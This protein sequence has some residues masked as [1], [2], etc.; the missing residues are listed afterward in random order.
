MKKILI[1]LV[2]SVGILVGCQSDPVEFDHE[3]PQ[4]EIR[5]NA[6]LLELIAPTGTTADDEI[7]I[8]GAF[9]GLNDTTAV[10]QLEW[11]LEKAQ[12]SD[13]KWGI[14]LQPEDFVNGKT[15]KDGFSFVSVKE[16][17]E[18]DVQ[19]KPM[20]HQLDVT[21]GTRTN[22]WSNRWASYFSNAEETIKHD[23]MVIYVLDES[24]FADLSLYMYGEI[25]DLNGAWPGM[26]PTGKE[27]INGVEYT[28]FDTG[29]DN[30]GL[31]ETLI[32]SDNGTNQLADYG[33]VLLEENIYLHIH[34]DGTIEAISAS[35]TVEH[36]GAVV[37]VLDGMNWGMNTTLYMW[38]DVNDLNGG[39]PGMKVGGTATI[40]E[41]TYIYFD[42]GEANTG[43]NE[44]LIF[45]NNGASQLDDYAYTIGEDIY[46]YIGDGAVSE[47]ADPENPGDVVW[48][49]PQAKPKEEAIV[50]LYLYDATD[51]LSH[52]VDSLGNPVEYT[53]GIFAWGSQEVFG[54]WPGMPLN[55]MDTIEILGLPLLHTTINC[56]VNDALNLIVNN[57]NGTQLS[58]YNIVATDSIN[59]YYLK[60]ADTG[61]TPLQVAAQI[62]GR[63]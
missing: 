19:G 38:G 63:K 14:Y 39:W 12:H 4:F 58:D 50:E 46:L 27:T 30:K 22:V 42:M 13:S 24:G 52:G 26:K 8:F 34:A 18:C 48:Y 32:F 23:G 5:A 15:L 43:L 51:T 57:G 10:G 53:L 60:I 16:G 35:S 7:Y 59:E 9:N 25:N 2:A 40:G 49:D 45:S 61:V 37:Y 3:Q 17:A 47:I 6:I 54:D 55:T 11:K 31:S 29:E 56:Y 28:Y 44:N 1:A 20:L 21:V 62:Q 41:Y 36:D 33:P